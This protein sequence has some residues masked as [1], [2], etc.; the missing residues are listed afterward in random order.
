MAARTTWDA[1]TR[2][3]EYS[4]EAEKLRRSWIKPYRRL[5]DLTLVAWTRAS[6]DEGVLIALER[7]SACMAQRGFDYRKPSDAMDAAWADR[8]PT[9]DTELAMADV[10]CKDRTNLVETWSRVEAGPPAKGTE[11]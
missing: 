1:L 4:Q 11:S 7:W 9:N 5:E 10:S 3:A 8:N 2:P 6:S